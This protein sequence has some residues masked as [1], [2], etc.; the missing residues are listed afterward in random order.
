MRIVLLA[1]LAFAL[2]A[3]NTASEETLDEPAPGAVRAETEP[4]VPVDTVSDYMPTEPVADAMPAGPEVVARGAF[5]GDSGHDASG[6]AV[7]YRLDDG[8][9]SVRL[10]GFTVDNGPALEVWLVQ[11]TS[12]DIARGGVSLGALKSTNG[13]Q[14]YVVP[15]GTDAASFAGVSIWCERF[16][17]NFGTAPLG[18]V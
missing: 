7:L 3:C 15:A 14:N 8:S 12:G 1:T 5:S 13:N 11:R 16:S 4:A 17:V 6:E 2:T 10:E 9:Y 18:G